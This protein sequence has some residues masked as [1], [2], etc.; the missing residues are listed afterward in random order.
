MIYRRAFIL[1]LILFVLLL[2][3]CDADEPVTV[4]PTEVLQGAVVPTR[5]T[6]T[7]TDTPTSTATSTSTDTPSPT[8]TDTPT[9]TD[10]PTATATDTPTPTETDTP[11]P[12]ATE[13]DTPVPT[14]TDT[15]TPTDTP[16]PTVTA[17]DI[18]AATPEP[19]S[20][21]VSI[22]A[23]TT[24]DYGDSRT[25]AI[26]GFVYEVEYTFEGQ[27]GD[28]VTIS[29][30][31][32]TGNLD[33]YLE[34]YSPEGELLAFNDDADIS[35]LNARIDSFRLPASGMFTVVA[36]RFSFDLGT[37][38]G[39]FRL[40]LEGI[41]STEVIQTESQR[42]TYGDR[43]TGE[44]TNAQPSQ[45]YTFVASAGD[46][47]GIQMNALAGSDLDAFVALLNPDGMEIAFNDDDPEVD[48]L[49]A[50]L[51]DFVIPADGIYTIVA[52]RFN[53]D[54]G[55]STG[56]YELIL[57]AA[58]AEHDR[59][60][61][62]APVTGEIS[63]EVYYQLY[64][65]EAEP[66]TV[67][68]FRQRPAPRSQLDPLLILLDASGR[69]IARSGEIA[70]WGGL[71]VTLDNITLADS[72]PYTLVATRSDR[73]FGTTIGEYVL[74]VAQTSGESQRLLRANVIA[75][76]DAITGVLDDAI[77]QRI[78][79]FQATRGEVINIEMRVLSGNL[80]PVLILENAIIGELKYAI[81][82]LFSDDDTLTVRI[83]RFVIPFDGHYSIIAAKLPDSDGEF[84]LR[85]TSE[86]VQ[87]ADE[88]V[89]PSAQII[90]AYSFGDFD[91]GLQSI[92]YTA[93]DWQDDDGESSVRTL[94]TYY[95]PDPQT[96]QLPATAILDLTDCDIFETSPFDVF[97]PM[98]IYLNG[99]YTE[100]RQMS[101]IFEP[102]ASLVA[103]AEDC[104]RVDLS[105]VVNRAYE[106]GASIIQIYLSFG[107]QINPNE[108]SES[109]TFN[110]PRLE[111]H[112]E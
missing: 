89:V 107:D 99:L 7:P 98:G 52:T 93:G 9:P 65:F 40:T 28:V 76:G 1:P 63:D 11:T 51:R 35:T 112:G 85:Y 71:G 10:T 72:G 100:N 101:A 37:T 6:S 56:E 26:E 102:G 86:G 88:V 39:D 79:T 43:V 25:G 45:T 78:F 14:L 38:E 81:A 73:R 34:L 2:A 54:M 21:D 17:T 96:I 32:T 80:D 83:N 64:T 82:P 41:T 12:T 58:G 70:A 42:L 84:L 47:I 90:P 60:L 30:D 50:Y 105:D 53:R 59:L 103:E 48:T 15:D 69:E 3:A 109:V 92:F 75:P 22:P 104:A 108:S 16:A 62:G 5:A 19:T 23:I 8:A 77:P 106:Q 87:S 95:L 97:G 29:M 110:N 36:T 27:V 31:A 55:I 13:T 94:L 4:E 49:N 67:Y 46:Q 111:V 66:G 44:I 24:L 91:D 18:P 20:A 57:E 74:D 61:I 33:P 68:T